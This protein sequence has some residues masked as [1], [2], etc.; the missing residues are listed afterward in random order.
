MKPFILVYLFSGAD[1]RV[2]TQEKE[3]NSLIIKKDKEI[4][5]LKDNNRLQNEV[6]S[7]LKKKLQKIE[8]ENSELYN[9]NKQL[10]KTIGFFVEIS[11]LNK[12]DSYH[13]KMKEQEEVIINLQA[14]IQEMKKALFDE[15]SDSATR[16][17]T[18]TSHKNETQAST[19]RMTVPSRRTE[20]STERNSE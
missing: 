14:N 12:I 9:K 13:R 1:E 2:I 19:T 18:R 20:R 6:L 17:T 16:K 15:S 5:A 8:V 3:E 11:M 7:N 10:E 4:I